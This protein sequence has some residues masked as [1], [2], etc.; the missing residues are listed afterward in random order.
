MSVR[1]GR[2][3]AAGLGEPDGPTESLNAP[4]RGVRG[5]ARDQGGGALGAA[6]E[7]RGGA[8]RSARDQ[9]GGAPG[10]AR[11]P[12]AGRWSRFWRAR[13]RP[14]DFYPPS[15]R[16]RE[17]L[18][19]HVRPGDRVLEVGAGS[20]RDSA[21]LARAGARAFLLDA[22]AG[23]LVLASRADAE[24][25]GRSLVQGDGLHAPFPDASFDLVF[26]QGLLEHFPDPHP[27]LAE[28]RRLLRPGGVLLVDVPQTFHPWTALK[29]TLIALDRWFAGWETQYT[30]PELE[31]LLQESGFEV[32]TTYGDWMN[33]SLAYRLVRQGLRAAGVSLPLEPPRV[34]VL[35]ALRRRAHDTLLRRRAALFTAFTIGVVARLR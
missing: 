7:Q 27:L 33:P 12:D 34:P 3:D 35:T 26:H 17:H 15:P 28:N 5:A 31:R 20:G 11:E 22:S 16:I 14:E 19:R 21:T 24:F 9:R 8:L 18:L 2:A 23:A 30:A 32:T 29:K 4:A 6:G 13:E 1:P 25:R 10:D